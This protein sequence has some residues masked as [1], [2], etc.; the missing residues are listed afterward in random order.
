MILNYSL[1]DIKTKRKQRIFEFVLQLRVAKDFVSTDTEVKFIKTID[2]GDSMFQET[3]SKT[4]VPTMKNKRAD[5]FDHSTIK[6]L[7]F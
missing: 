7:T 5:F 4:R 3:G 2:S 6:S 1:F